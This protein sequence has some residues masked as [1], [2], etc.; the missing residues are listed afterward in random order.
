MIHET[1]T[2]PGLA[3]LF[4]EAEAQ[5]DALDVWERANLREMQRESRNAAAIDPVLLG[6]LT[7]ARIECEM[8]WRAA[9]PSGD[10]RAVLPQF[11]R[12][13]DLVRE[14]GVQKAA[15]LGLG[16][17]DALHDDYEPGG[18]AA[19]IDPLFDDLANTLPNF[20]DQALARQALQS[21]AQRLE[22]LFDTAAQKT[23]G[24]RVMAMVGFD[25][26]MGAPG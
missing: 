4:A 26:S 14:R 5:Q 3:D 2:A 22:G 17:Y 23:L 25:F 20:L 10:F 8:A 24:K 15:A 11:T 6:H 13:L 12:L 1:L 9:R 7:E 21:M 16:L 18:R 19:R